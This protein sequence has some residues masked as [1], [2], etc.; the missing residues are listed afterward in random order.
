MLKVSVTGDGIK[1]YDG[2]ETKQSISTSAV[3][4][5]EVQS[6]IYFLQN[7]L[8]NELIQKSNPSDKKE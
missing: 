4:F 7:Y 2:Q 1:P 5:Q 8:F 6:F 3:V